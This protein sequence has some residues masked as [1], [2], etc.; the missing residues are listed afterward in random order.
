MRGALLT[1][2]A[3][4]RTGGVADVA[5]N[6][7]REM[8]GEGAGRPV[9]LYLDA[10]V[11]REETRIAPDP[12][13]QVLARP[14]DLAALLSGPADVVLAVRGPVR[15]DLLALLD[16][17][18]LIVVI[19]DA[20]VVSLRAAQRTLRLLTDVGYPVD[21]VEVAMVH[22]D[23]A[24]PVEHGDA[25]R[26]ALRRPHVLVLPRVPAAGDAAYRT[27]VRRLRGA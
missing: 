17:S 13:E 4:R 16:R 18:R 12:S 19:T 23:P 5:R 8:R 10:A 14:A 7:V 2:L 22:Q 9:A 24:V 3:D 26:T 27:L 20:A 6:V 25:L 21:R 11:A 1:L 15:Q